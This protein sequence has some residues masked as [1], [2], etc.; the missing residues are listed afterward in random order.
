MSM[1]F[2]K[3]N[4][5]G[6]GGAVEAA[7]PSGWSATVTAA[8]PGIVRLAELLNTDDAMCPGWG[9]EEAIA[10]TRACVPRRYKAAKYGKNEREAVSQL[11]LKLHVEYSL[12]S[13]GCCKK[14]N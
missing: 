1:T 6:F 11:R 7:S 14:P 10:A 8:L 3:T 13:A 4:G 5:Q 9:K 2:F 12:V